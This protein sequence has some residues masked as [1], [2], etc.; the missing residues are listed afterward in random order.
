MSR[1]DTSE[2]HV[3]EEVLRVHGSFGYAYH[4]F[5]EILRARDGS[6]AIRVQGR[7]VTFWRREQGGWRVTLVLTGRSA[8]DE[9]L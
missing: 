8:P 9:A 2:M 3:H 7:M 1:F 5:Q 4:T 6:L